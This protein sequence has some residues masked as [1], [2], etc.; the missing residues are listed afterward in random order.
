MQVSPHLH[1]YSPQPSSGLTV[2]GQASSSSHTPPH[3]VQCAVHQGSS[4]QWTAV[5]NNVTVVLTLRWAGGETAG[6]ASQQ[7]PLQELGLLISAEFTNVTKTIFLTNLFDIER[8]LLDNKSEIE[9]NKKAKALDSG[10]NLYWKF[11]IKNI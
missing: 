7:S 8:G 1:L 3:L 5:H 9:F 6:P 2:A 10:A 4:K 11:Y